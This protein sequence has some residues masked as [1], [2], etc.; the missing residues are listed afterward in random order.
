VPWPTVIVGLFLQQAIA[1]F[2]L[3]T[4]AGF[5]IFTWIAT[6]ASDFLNQSQAGAT[7]FFSADV[8]AKGYFFVNTL[9]AII[10]FVAFVHML[11][12]LGIM[13]WLLAKFAW[14]F[15]KLLDVSGAEAVVAAS[16]PW[17]G[18]GESAVLVKPY[19]DL[20]T[21]SEIHLI[22]TS[23]FACISGSVMSFY[24]RLGVPAQNIITS[25]VMSIPASIAI[26]KIRYPEI[27]EPV[28][29]GRIVVDRGTGEK[30]PPVRSIPPTPLCKLICTFRLTFCMHSVKEL[31]SV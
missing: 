16:S 9:A 30:H 13:Q 15:F 12:Y 21:R 3:K 25:S 22:M 10:F 23:G 24:I 4:S 6:L 27:D 20:M 26:S 29:K 7:F 1:M 19:V 2:V 28:T 5:S 17:L 14:F 11:Y 8:V 18:Q 31:C